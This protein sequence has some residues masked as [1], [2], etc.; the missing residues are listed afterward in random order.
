MSHVEFFEKNYR[1]HGE[2]VQASVEGWIGEI[3]GKGP[4]TQ[5]NGALIITDRRIVFVRKGIIGNIF[6]AI[7]RSKISSL[8]TKSLLGHV[9]A[10]FHTSHDDL[11]FKTFNG[12]ALKVVADLFNRGVNEPAYDRRPSVS[13][14]SVARDLEMLLQLRED[15]ELTRTEYEAAKQHVLK[16]G[17]I[18]IT[19]DDM[20]YVDPV[21]PS[22]QPSKKSQGGWFLPALVLSV[23]GYFA[24]QY[25]PE[26]TER[27][28]ST[29]PVKAAQ[30]R[31]AVSDPIPLTRPVAEPVKT[32][33]P[34]NR[35]VVSNAPRPVAKICKAAV[36]AIMG[37][38]PSIISVGAEISGVLPLSYVRPDDGKQCKYRCRVEG[39]RIIWASDTGRWRTD[40]LDEKIF[41]TISSNTISISERYTDGSSN[42]STYL[43]G[44]L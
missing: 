14:P 17:S 25:F 35:S 24:W 6:E 31:T 30:A 36:A 34:P 8:E 41:Y 3:F 1:Q 12:D 42:E 23:A 10:R 27:L 5:H 33:V 40:P 15:G 20:I 16:N 22:A 32:Y 39:D 7:P 37:R 18:A 44:Q 26:P 28:P 11:T 2:T 9:T 21:V 19:D 43:L 29:A 38:D 4:K 13:N